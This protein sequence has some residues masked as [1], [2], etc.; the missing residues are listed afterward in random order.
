MA[1][2]HEVKDEGTHYVI[3]KFAKKVTGEK[4]KVTQYSHNA[5]IVTFEIP[6][7]VE[8]HDMM[9]SDV[10]RVH[11]TNISKNKKTLNKGVY[12]V[13]DKRLSEDGNTV[14]FSWK[15]SSQGTQI[16]GILQFS[17]WFT[18]FSDAPDF[19]WGTETNKCLIFIVASEK[20]SDAIVQEYPDVLDEW[21]NDLYEQKDALLIKCTATGES[22]VLKDSLEYPLLALSPSGENVPNTEVKLLGGNYFNINNVIPQDDGVWVQ[23]NGFAMSNYYNGCW[24]T[25]GALCPELRDGD[26]VYLNFEVENAGPTIDL[27]LFGTQRDWI[28][29]NSLVITQAD[30][31]DAFSIYGID[32]ETTVYKNI[33]VSKEPIPFEPYKEPQTV[34]VPCSEEE[35]KEIRTYYPTTTIVADGEVTVT[36]ATDTKN[37]IDNKLKALEN[38]IKEIENHL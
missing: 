8:G 4:L 14:L 18:Y 15:I 5:E 22:I 11:Y 23:D 31:D 12:E 27:Y 35:L 28:P 10:V 3:D 33:I 2:L 24:T 19:E 13:D 36:Y 9:N 20:N 29:G 37:Y 38:R 7:F 26:E 6:R 21:K 1:H 17:V 30:L 16:D 34:T 25:L 32:G